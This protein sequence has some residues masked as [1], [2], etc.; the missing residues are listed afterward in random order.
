M[1]CE[2]ILGKLSDQEFEGLRVDYVDIEWHEAYSRLHRKTS[3]EGEDV[4]I[5]MGNEI[6]SVGLNQDDVLYADAQKVIAVNIPA[7]EAI[8]ARVRQD[9]PRQI[10]KLCYEVGNTHTTMF[11]GED[12][13]TFYTPFHEPLLE[14]INGI[15]GVTAEKVMKKF[16]FRQALS[17]SVNNH[18]H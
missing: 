11:R 13:F 3:A 7:C 15:H 8:R 14:K 5:R 12:D 9:H 2:K 6:L 18:H 16:D 10:A 1:L 4:G 17:S